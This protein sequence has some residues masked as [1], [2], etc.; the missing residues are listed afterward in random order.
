M[1]LKRVDVNVR[2]AKMIKNR[3]FKIITK[4]KKKRK[5]ALASFTKS[6]DYF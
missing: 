3:K 6:H 2:R 4:N 1:Q 5:F